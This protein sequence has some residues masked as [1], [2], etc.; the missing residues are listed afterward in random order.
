MKL[1][2]ET[3]R[4]II[5]QESVTNQAWKYFNSTWGFSQMI[6]SEVPSKEQ[7]PRNRDVFYGKYTQDGC[8]TLFQLEKTEI[9]D[10]VNNRPIDVIWIHGLRTLGD[11]QGKGSGT[12]VMH[13]IVD[14]ADTIGLG[15]AGS[16]VPYGSSKMTCEQMTAFDARF[17]LMPL[18]HWRNF[19]PQHIQEDE[20]AMWEIDDYIEFNEDQVWRP[21]GGVI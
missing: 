3:I 20:D 7:L 2:R 16:V 12:H 17:G 19:I 21:A 18:K 8:D 13:S 4:R 1:L 14:F 9:F 6:R 5:L 11:C 10:I 15:V